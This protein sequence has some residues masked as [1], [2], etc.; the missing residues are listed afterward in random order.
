MYKRQ[1]FI[2][3]ITNNSTDAF[4]PIILLVDLNRKEEEHDDADFDDF[5][6]NNVATIVVVIERGRRRS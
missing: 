6:E 5:D 1:I 2:I 4:V 3:K